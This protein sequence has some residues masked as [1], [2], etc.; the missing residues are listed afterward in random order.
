LAEE[1]NAAYGADV[2][3]RSLQ[4]GASLDPAALLNMFTVI[5]IILEIILAVLAVGALALI[6]L[7]YACDRAAESEKSKHYENDPR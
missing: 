2:L 7:F 3:S 1:I 6:A 5:A 4:L